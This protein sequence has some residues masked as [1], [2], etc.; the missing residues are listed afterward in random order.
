MINSVE[1]PV[2]KSSGVCEI[3]RISLWWG[4]VA[5]D[6][7]I[8]MV[9]GSSKRAEDIRSGDRVVSGNGT[10][11]VTDVVTGMEAELI[12]LTTQ[13]GHSVRVTGSHPI[14]TTR[15]FVQASE[16]TAADHILTINGESPI[17]FLYTESYHDM[18]Y[19][20]LLTAE[21]PMVCG[22][23]IAGDFMMQ[24][25]TG[26]RVANQAIADTPLMAEMRKLFAER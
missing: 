21:G 1:K 2:L 23:I 26:S 15:G 18:V 10:S 12:T 5:K 4:C 20:F 11:E 7:Q 24:N 14:G 17:K 3:E 8:L 6:T 16:L 22:G 13:N 25:E 19:N 9:D